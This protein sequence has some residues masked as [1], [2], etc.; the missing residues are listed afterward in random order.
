MTLKTS[1]FNKGIYKST[2]K[3]YVW[4]AILYTLLLFISV[5]L[6]LM[7]SQESLISNVGM[8]VHKPVIL[9]NVYII[10]PLIFSMFVPTVVGLLCFR[11]LHSKRANIFVHSL[12]PTRTTTYFST[13]VAAFT[14]MFAPVLINGFILIFMSITGCGMLFDVGSCLIWMGIQ[15]LSLFLMFSVTCFAATLT[16]NSFAMVILNGILHSVLPLVVSL[17]SQIAIMFLYGYNDTNILIDAIVEWN[18]VAY[19]ISNFSY[20]DGLEF[21]NNLF[22]LIIVVLS[23]LILYVVAFV[24][25]KKRSNEKTEEVAAYTCLNHIFK[26]LITFIASL[27]VLGLCGFFIVKNFVP[28]LIILMIVNTTTYFGLEMLLKKTFKVW[29]SYKGYLVYTVIL[30]VCLFI[31]I[32]TSF[33][34]FE[35]Y[36]PDVA[37]IEKVQIIDLYNYYRP[38]P[39]ETDTFIQ[40]ELVKQAVVNFHSESVQ[41]RYIKTVNDASYYTDN[42]QITYQLKNGKQVVRCYE[43]DDRGIDLTKELYKSEEYKSKYTEIFYTQF[44]K[45]VA[46]SIDDTLID[47]KELYTEFINVLRKDT[48]LLDYEQENGYSIP[49]IHYTIDYRDDYL[50]EIADKGVYLSIEGRINSNH[51]NTINFLKDNEIIE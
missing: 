17:L 45:I 23:A 21:A 16:G 4:G 12:P 13:L 30:G 6:T 50:S 3:R 32:F 9:E 14:L 26:Y 18:Y 15:F 44:D 49:N 39:E 5:P 43:T 41:P 51:V 29:K 11:F 1:L 48:L 7:L 34:G 24:L 20:F 47:N 2:V 10:F 19:I 42:I 35:T 40:D 27:I 28:L 8:Y 38:D 33:F 46:I 37:D 22:S 25:Y 36:V 31:T